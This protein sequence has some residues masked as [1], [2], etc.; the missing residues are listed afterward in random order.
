VEG[1]GRGLF[2]GTTRNFPGVTEDYYKVCHGSQSPGRDFNQRP[3]EYETVTLT[4]R[5]RRSFSVTLSSFLVEQ[6]LFSEKRGV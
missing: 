4:T 6:G 5:L 1:S 2:E 3:H